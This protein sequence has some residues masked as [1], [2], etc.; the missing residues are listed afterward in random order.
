LL[1]SARFRL[2]ERDGFSQRKTNANQSGL[3]PTFA[4]I[5]DRDKKHVGLIFSLGGK[6]KERG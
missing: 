6:N 4:Q 1:L 3:Y 5:I 2:G